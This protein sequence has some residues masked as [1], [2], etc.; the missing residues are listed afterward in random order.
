ET[1]HH[2]A[3]VTG[4]GL[5]GV[6]ERAPYDR[7][8]ATAAIREAVPRP[9]LEQLKPGGVL[10]SPW[11][12][13]WSN[14]VMLTLRANADGTAVGRFSG[15]LAF[16]RVRSQRRALYGWQ[17]DQGQIE[18]AEVSITECRGADLDRMLNP[19]LGNFA[20]G[21]HLDPCCLEVTWDANG[22]RRHVL[23]L[24]H[25][26]SRSWARL[27]ADLT[28]PEPWQVRQIGPRRLWDE[29]EAAYDWWHEQGEPGM[30]QFGVT[31]SPVQ[32]WLWLKQPENVVREL[33]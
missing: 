22:D 23:E 29:V 17:P 9:W 5:A 33:L 13:D 31:I 4:D 25:R 2:V 7:I 12:T 27:D 20:I 3:V 30:D 14:G 24:D 10:V 19:E 26:D 18:I 1:G 16:M 11:G 15:N 32:Q 28:S 6:P 21:A 8:I